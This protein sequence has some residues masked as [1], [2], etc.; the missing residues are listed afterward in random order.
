MANRI[1]VTAVILL[2]LGSMSWL[3][4]DKVLPSY[5]DGEPPPAA[6]FEPNVPVAWSVQWSGRMVGYAA[7]VRIPGPSNTTTLENRVVLDDVPLMD[8]VPALMR[9]V[10]GDIGRMKL[11]ASTR[12]EFDSLDN[13]TKFDSRVSINDIAGLLRMTGQV[14]GPFLDMTVKFNDVTYSPQVPV[15]N[16]G[17]LSESLFPDAK[18]PFMYVGR[19]WHEEIYSPFRT[20]S[21]PVDTVEVEVTGVES[22]E[23]DG[24]MER[25]MRVE[26]RGSE[27]SGVPEDARLQAVAWVRAEDGLV[28]RQ[29]V[30]IA[31]SSLRF[32]R[33]GE[34]RAAEVG[35]VLLTQPVRRRRGGRG[36][37]GRNG[38]GAAGQTEAAPA[39]STR[40]PQASA[41][42]APDPAT[43][44]LPAAIDYEQSPLDFLPGDA[45]GARD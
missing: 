22:L 34:A 9:Q 27:E 26:F 43:V 1:F 5:T 25:V 15:P 17:A 12:L 13:F 32:D 38:G 24:E 41:A 33:L 28:L 16:Q 40:S 6:G 10:V 18:L 44:P 45:P 4:V 23:R 19:K 31:S 2:W 36:G 30:Y 21:D 37:R 8:L 39:D 20:P 7:S 42:I 14:N 29:D 35:R 3:M 11:D